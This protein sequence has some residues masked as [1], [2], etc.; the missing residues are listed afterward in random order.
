MTSA[1]FPDAAGKP[2]RDLSASSWDDRWKT[3]DTPWD[4]GRASPPLVR[5]LAEW[6]PDGARGRAL[7]PGCGAGHDA[8]AAA[9]AG[10][11][12]TGIDLSPLAVAAAAPAPRCAFRVADLFALPPDLSDFDLVVEHTCF[13]AID[14]SM[15]DRYVDAVAGVLRPGG[16]LLAL[17]W[18]ITTEKGPPFGASEAEIRHRFARRFTFEREESPAD[19]EPSRPRERLCLL[20]RIR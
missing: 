12:T 8:R 11:D 1:P 19:S 4:L 9:A 7:V 20:R 3:G 6:F 10:W 2:S 16:A 14:P 13:C 17:F 15:R 18:L 5:A